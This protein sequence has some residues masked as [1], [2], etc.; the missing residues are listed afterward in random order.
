MNVCIIPA[1]GG[2]KRIPK[3]NIKTFLGQP[4]IAYSIQT[5][6]HSCCFDKVIVSTDD[7]EISAI[8]NNY[9]AITPFV[10]PRELSG[11]YTPTIPV[12]KHAIN[13][14][15]ENE[16]YPDNVCCI[17]P[18][19][20]FLKSETIKNSLNIFE[21]NNYDYCF[22][23]TNF[24]YPIQRALLIDEKNRVS[25]LDSKM[26]NRRSQDLVDA[27]HDIGQFYW[28]KANSFKSELP[29]FNVNSIGYKVESYLVNDI[30]TI[31]DW[32]RAEIMYQY[33]KDL[34]EI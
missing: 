12:N 2:S 27:Y 16:V 13:W 17:Y 18:T 19:A 25:M 22:G 11:D 26:Y 3:K 14:L 29:M 30:D 10:R 24:N 15:E 5:A 7:A 21:K 8:S 20:P 6:I 4:I 34:K 31:D 28:G 32:K 9:R 1:R 33:L 23:V